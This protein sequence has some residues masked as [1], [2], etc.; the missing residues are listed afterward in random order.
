MISF[1]ISPTLP[2]AEGDASIHPMEALPSTGGEPTVMVRWTSSRM[3][4]AVEKC[5]CG[6][7]IPYRSSNGVVMVA[8]E[9]RGS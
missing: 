8:V 5:R 1:A 7:K 3:L 4:E 2:D 6:D 9:I